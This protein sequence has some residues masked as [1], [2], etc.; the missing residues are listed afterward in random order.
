MAASLDTSN[1][2]S[3]SK[4]SVIG[5]H[6]IYKAVWTP[7]IGESLAVNHKID[8]AYDSHAVTV[9]LDDCVVGHLPQTISTVLWLV[10]LLIPFSNS[11]RVDFKFSCS[12]LLR[13]L[14]S[15]LNSF[16]LESCI[17]TLLF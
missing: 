9:H 8:N 2:T 6:H 7:F 11:F 14:V 17:I 12:G 4:E 13:L 1:S 10:L 5:G 16:Q 15:D 3:Y